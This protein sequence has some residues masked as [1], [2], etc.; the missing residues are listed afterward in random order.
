MSIVYLVVPVSARAALASY[1]PVY[2]TELEDGRVIAKVKE[3]PDPLPEGV[4][5]LVGGAEEVR[6]MV[7]ELPGEG[8]NAL[9]RARTSALLA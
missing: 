3:L 4:E 6:R 1:N 2:G 7:F 5:S 9:L 8:G